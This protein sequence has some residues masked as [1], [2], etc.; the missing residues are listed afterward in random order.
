[1]HNK[2]YLFDYQLFVINKE[3]LLTNKEHLWQANNT[4]AIQR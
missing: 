2:L 4:D 1:M 3:H